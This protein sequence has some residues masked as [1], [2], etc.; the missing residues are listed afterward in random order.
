[1]EVFGFSVCSVYSHE[2]SFRK[3]NKVKFQAFFWQFSNCNLVDG[4]YGLNELAARLSGAAETVKT[5]ELPE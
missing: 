5:V 1:L 4:Q 3:L 2:K